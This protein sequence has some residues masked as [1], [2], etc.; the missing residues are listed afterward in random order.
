[1]PKRPQLLKAV[2]DLA[3]GTGFA[4]DQ[5]SLGDTKFM[6][7]CRLPEDLGEHGRAKEDLGE[8][9]RAEEDLGEHSRAK[10]TWASTVGPRKTWASTVRP[11]MTWAST[12]GPR[13]TWAST[14]G[15]NVLAMGPPLIFHAL[16]GLTTHGASWQTLE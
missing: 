3:L 4:T 13:K 2:V 11:R 10:K 14:V 15:P 9:G 12:V 6:G 16:R 7:V 1:M 8:H 5:I